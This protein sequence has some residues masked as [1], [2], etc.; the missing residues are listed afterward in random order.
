MRNSELEELELSPIVV[1]D[2]TGS[3]NLDA[4]G[5]LA[6]MLEFVDT[7]LGDV[8]S[9]TGFGEYMISPNFDT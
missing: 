2:A 1:R 3:S 4:S 5:N 6:D 9:H 7:L 8:E